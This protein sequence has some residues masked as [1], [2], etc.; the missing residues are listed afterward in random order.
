MQLRHFLFEIVL[1]HKTMQLHEWDLNQWVRI[2][3]IKQCIIHTQCLFFFFLAKDKFLRSVG[4]LRFEPRF[5]IVVHVHG[6]TD[7][8]TD[9]QI[10]RQTDRQT[11]RGRETDGQKDG[12]TERTCSITGKPQSVYHQVLYFNMVNS[13]RQ[14]LTS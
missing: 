12:Q 13:S 9:R 1:S 10:G 3:R 14:E 2:P 7:R 5:K 11:D 6:Q 8:Q 4:G